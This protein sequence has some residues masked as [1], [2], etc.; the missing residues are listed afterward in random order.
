MKSIRIAYVVSDLKRVGPTNQT[1]N[2]IKNSC[3][4]KDSILI[5]L[6]KE[7][8]NDTMIKE[9]KTN[10]IEVLCLN[11]NR[12]S[13]IITGQKKILKILKKYQI[14]LVHSYGIKPDC[15]CEKVCKKINIKHIITL[16]NYPKEDILTR[17]NFIKGRIALYNHLNALL[18]CDN[19]ICCSKSIADLMKKDYPKHKFNY[20]QNGV[21]IDKFKKINSSEK[22]K[23]R[24]KYLIDKNKLVY[25]STGSMI[26]RKRINET[27]EGFIKANMKDSLLLLLGDGPLLKEIKNEYENNNNII[28]V[29]KTDKV[30]EY[31][32][33][34]DVFISS[35]ESEGLPNSVLEAIACG[36]PIILSNIPQH[37]EIIME[38][39]CAGKCYKL[40]DINELATLI[41]NIKKDKC[42]CNITDSSFNML[43]MS[44]KYTDYYKKILQEGRNK[45]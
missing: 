40:G 30:I 28:F 31:L 19:V 11:L 42:R 26:H 3:Y 27:I 4:K 5:T 2:I 25:I 6:F 18:K 35:S 34:S 7:D 14:N 22:E 32:Q 23:L 16:R 20:I 24:E 17:M 1:L 33:L 39:P 9:Y 41:N 8:D 13:F 43:N 44:K 36:L 38:L 21:D 37:K 12:I 15:L 45:K 10:S 29:G